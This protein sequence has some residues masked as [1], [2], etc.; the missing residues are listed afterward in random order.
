MQLGKKLN[1]DIHTVLADTNISNAFVR[2]H[3]H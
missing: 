1:T 2:T 3:Y